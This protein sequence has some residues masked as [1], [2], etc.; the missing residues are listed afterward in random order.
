MTTEPTLAELSALWRRRNEPEFVGERSYYIR[1]AER[2]LALGEPLFACDVCAQALGSGIEGVA[3]DARLR[4]L[5]GLALARSGALEPALAEAAS[6]VDDGHRD[7]EALG[8]LA[9]INKDLWLTAADPETATRS[10]QASRELYA[11]AYA[12]SGGYW[13]G[14]NAASLSLVAGEVR[15]AERLA[16]EVR[17]ACLKLHDPN[18]RDFW[19]EATL[20]EAALVLGDLG[21]ARRWYG[22]ASAGNRDFGSLASTRR[23]A[24][25]LLNSR[26]LDAGWLNAALPAPTIA[27][28]SGHTPD[29]RNGTAE[30]RFPQSAEP[31]VGNRLRALIAESGARI[32]YGS[33]ACGSDILFHEAMLE[34]GGET[35][36]VLPGS[37]ERFEEESVGREEDWPGRYARVLERAAS[38]TVLSQS[39]EG[40]L[41]FSYANWILLG[42]ARL[43]ARQTDGQVQACAVWDGEQG[44]PGGTAS[45]VHDWRAFGADVLSLHPRRAEASLLPAARAAA[46]L[47]GD[48]E[49]GQ[50]IV[51]MLFADAVGFSKLE[52]RQVPL[53]VTHFLGGVARLLEQL[54]ERPLTR[55]TW[56]DGLYFSFATPRGAG[57]LALAICDFARHADWAAAGLPAE[58]NVRIALHAGPAYH[59]FDPVIGQVN[60]TGAHVS[61]AARIE[62]VTP[63][64]HVYASQAFAALC[65]CMQIAEFA[66]D[67]VGQVPLAKGY[68][69]FPMFH[70]RRSAQRKPAA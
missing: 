64:G 10:L 55:N 49:A 56:G 32:G 40:D 31:F 58:M 52:D 66:C 6:L 50:R 38:V 62:P 29:R 45:A 14:I 2:A 34:A 16:A 43:R 68:G 1:L 3:G 8:L 23:N 63:P 48:G 35:H 9:R 30:P 41:A 42:L 28:F 69:T 53:F 44:R 24:A 54:S 70:V 19:L 7:E 37:P 11:E 51:T 15:E 59:V 13:T 57:Q 65:E 12:A 39:R 67:Y 27:V 17:R 61:R 20:G 47:P 21:E 46:T 25:L 36:V 5:N 60:F 22:S 4:A 26:K 18:R 33:A